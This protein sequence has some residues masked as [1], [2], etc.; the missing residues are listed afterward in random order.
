LLADIF[1]FDSN[2]IENDEK[3][4]AIKAEILREGSSDNE[5]GSEEGD[6]EGDEEGT[7]ENSRLGSCLNMLQPSSRQ[8]IEDGTET[9]LDDLRRI[10]PLTMHHQIPTVILICRMTLATA[11]LV[12]ARHRPVIRGTIRL[13]VGEMTVGHHHHAALVGTRCAGAMTA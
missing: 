12:V 8:G 1:K 13:A 7:F 5:P 10:C 9:N 2:Y 3:Y 6:S 4:K 11:A